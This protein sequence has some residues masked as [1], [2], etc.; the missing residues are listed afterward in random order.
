MY[1]KNR[2]NA[3]FTLIE[4]M[5]VI[6]IIGILAAMVIPNLR[7]YRERAGM[8]TALRTG[9]EILNSL[10]AYSVTSIGNRYPP[11]I[12]TA[13][14]LIDIVR[15][16]GARITAKHLAPFQGAAGIS[17]IEYV[18]FFC[19]EDTGNCYRFDWVPVVTPSGQLMGPEDFSL[20]LPLDQL[21]ET[22]P[23]EEHLF[24]E[25]NS[26]DG[27]SILTGRPDTTTPPPGLF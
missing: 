1:T 3:G 7:Q 25:V 17:A 4:L 9:H 15:R 20:L 16:N 2:R 10:T 19:D 24:L 6:C 27:V 21:N 13:D 8:A 23:V 5:L 14:E 12:D 18:C 22:R 26:F 11:T